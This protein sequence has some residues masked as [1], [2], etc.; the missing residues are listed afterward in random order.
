MKL[1]L[2]QKDIP[3][4]YFHVTDGKEEGDSAKKTEVTEIMDMNTEDCVTAPRNS[5]F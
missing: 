1:L 2:A 3:D 4:L 5:N